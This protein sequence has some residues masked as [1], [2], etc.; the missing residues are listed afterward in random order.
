MYPK[1]MYLPINK[2]GEVEITSNLLIE[3]LK[4]TGSWDNWKKELPMIRIRNNL[5]NREEMY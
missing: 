4:L 5:A 3:G 2:K 1:K